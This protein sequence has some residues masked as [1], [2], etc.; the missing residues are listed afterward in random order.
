MHKLNLV[1][2]D[3]VR[4]ALVDSGRVA[5][6][7]FPTWIWRGSDLSLKQFFVASMNFRRACAYFRGRHSVDTVR[8]RSTVAISLRLS[9]S[10]AHAFQSAMPEC[11][12]L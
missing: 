6:H 7:I 11:N 12:F 1:V 9:I 8:S 3:R 4:G 2:Q 10:I 5:P